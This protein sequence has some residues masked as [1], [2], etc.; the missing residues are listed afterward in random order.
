MKNIRRVLS[1]AKPLNRLRN[2]IILLVV[3]SAFLSQA[4]PLATKFAVEEL[5]KEI[6][7]SNGDLD[8]VIYYLLIG[9]GLGLVRMSLTV[10]SARLGDKYAG[11]LRKYLISSFYY[12]ILNLPQK[13]FDNEVSGKIINQLNRGV[14][15]IQGFMN[16][17]TNFILLSLLQTTIT[18][19][20]LLYFS[21]IV[22]LLIILIFPIYIWLSNI[23][24][25]RWGELEVPKNQLEDRTR[26]RIS[27]VISNIRLVR[28]FGK[29][30]SEVELIDGLQGSINDIYKDQ[31]SVFHK[32][33]F[34]RKLALDVILLSI[35]CVLFINSFNG[36]Y[37]IGQ[38][39]LVVQLIEMLRQPLYGMSFILTQLQN[40][41]A[42]TKEFFEII[43]LQKSEE[44]DAKSKQNKVLKINK[45]E[46]DSLGFKY[47]DESVFENLSLKINKGEK[48][49]LVGKS[50]SGKSTLINLIMRFYDPTSGKIKFN[51][52]SHSELLNSEIRNSIS[53]VFQDS[54]L[55]SS[56]IRENIMYGNENVDELEV[57]EAL[58]KANAYEFVTNFKD[59]LDTEIGERGIRLSGGQKQRIQIARAI[60]KDS[61][62]VIL[63][64]AT[65]SLDNESETLVQEAIDNL[66]RDKIVI[67]I[68]H[69]LTTIKNVD[70]IL[71][72]NEGELK[73][74]YSDYAEF[75]KKENGNLSKASLNIN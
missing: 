28:G 69:R 21:P 73:S 16:N 62:V 49:A 35:Y 74:E 37:S 20:V 31:S 32:Y 44:F 6:S 48:V 5:E 41:N 61:S 33:D 27:E 45:I 8:R 29:Q 1:Y 39:I 63:D 36:T 67:I 14:W 17:F 60:L 54:E 30:S 26:G 43:Q 50:G 40:A 68:A 75:M 7:S 2:T 12:H 66:T 71:V 4:F 58:K 47:D 64:E 19:G 34:L 23:S 11:E 9:F 70:R 18:I 22:G 38:L 57:L 72:I 52:I 56:T 13:Y 53:M 59:G 10:L 55:F 46:I 24:S 65:S 3:L 15:T 42:G 25:K 51:G